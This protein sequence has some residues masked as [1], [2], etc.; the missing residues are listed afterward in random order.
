MEITPHYGIVHEPCW[1]HVQVDNWVPG[2]RMFLKENKQN[3]DMNNYGLYSD[4]YLEK[5]VYKL[6]DCY[7]RL[8]VWF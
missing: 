4:K 1:I 6:F 7:W 5:E 3:I 2:T 8:E